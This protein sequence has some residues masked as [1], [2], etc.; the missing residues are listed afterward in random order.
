[1]II[2][3][4]RTDPPQRRFVEEPSDNPLWQLI[5][6]ISDKYY[7]VFYAIMISMWERWRE[8]LDISHLFDGLLANNVSV[9]N[10]VVE[11][12]WMSA[13]NEL[14]TQSRPIIE[15]MM[16]ESFEISST[17]IHGQLGAEF[18]G[19]IT[20]DVRNWITQHTG[21]FIT[22]VGETERMAIREVIL[23]GMERGRNAAT[24]ARDI[25]QHIGLTRPQVETISRLRESMETAN[26][27]E[28][29]I[30]DVIDKRIKKMI[31]QRAQVIARN[32]TIL[33]SKEGYRQSY[34]DAANQGLI[35][36]NKSRR[37]WVITPLDAC[38]ICRPIPGMNPNGVG[39]YEPFQ[40]PIGPLLNVH[41]HIQCRC[42]ETMSKV[43]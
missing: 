11:Q 28:K 42:V 20:T 40:T 2:I 14:L 41:A 5:H 30:E 25:R 9:V 43:Q 34:L 17:R 38:E 13:E 15:E 24:M 8:R 32:E 31:R 7:P 39:L 23:N 29:R 1:M 6:R 4:A 21:E 27:P 12:A 10:S 16:T 18:F 35:D 33:A 26:I 37:Y 22:Q 19:G 36:A 3:K